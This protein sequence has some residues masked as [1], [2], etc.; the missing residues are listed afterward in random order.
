MM[1]SSSISVTERLLILILASLPVVGL[2][3]GPS[4]AALVFSAG[5]IRFFYLL[6]ARRGHLRVDPWFV[7]LAAAF[8][9]LAAAGGAWSLQPHRT[10]TTAGQTAAVFGMALIFLAGSGTLSDRA[11]SILSVVLPLGVLAGAVVI[12]LDTVMA[13][14]L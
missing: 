11:I 7:I 3:A 9:L 5:L 14:P 8:I 2:V 6:K 1:P 13:Y 12:A 10:L 4:Y